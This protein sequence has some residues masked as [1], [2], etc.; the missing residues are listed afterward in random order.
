M[1]SFAEA[2]FSALSI[3]HIGNK[4]QDEYFNLS[5]EPL[6]LNDEVLR[7]LLI[8]YFLKPFEKVN[9]V[10]RFYHSSEDL[11]LNELHNFS[12]SIFNNAGSFHEKSQQLARYLYDVTNHPNIKPGELYVAFFENI[13]LEG[14]RLDAIGVFKS[15]TKDTYLKVYP[16]EKG[17]GIDYE[18]EAIN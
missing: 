16:E 12:S 1:I 10:Y 17:Y 18:Q 6:Q 8:Q 5:D 7:N 2:T 13:Q 14:E 11:N 3:H 9:E 4:A 15:E